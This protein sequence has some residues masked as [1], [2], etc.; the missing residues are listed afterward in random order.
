MLEESVIDVRTTHAGALSAMAHE[1]EHPPEPVQEESAEPE[2]SQPVET[3]KIVGPDLMEIRPFPERIGKAL[4]DAIEN[5][6]SA[7]DGFRQWTIKV[8]RNAPSLMRVLVSGFVR[9]DEFEDRNAIC[10]VC[11]DRIIA[12]RVINDNRTVIET[13]YCRACECGVWWLARLCFKNRFK[14]WK[15]PKLRHRRSRYKVAAIW[16]WIKGT[17]FKGNIPADMGRP[18]NCGK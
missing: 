2:R 3:K 1:R 18:C 15:C 12:L 11:P 5:P 10:D 8:V 7:A 4:A 6:A 17:E 14:G 9:R 16:S 13:Q